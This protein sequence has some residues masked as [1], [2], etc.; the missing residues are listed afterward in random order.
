MSQYK[1][2]TQHSAF[3][4]PGL[5]QPTQNDQQLTEMPTIELAPVEVQQTSDAPLTGVYSSSGFDM[6]GV[7]SR[8]VNRYTT[9][10]QVTIATNITFKKTKPS[11]QL[12][13]N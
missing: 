1:E 2:K 7:L 4:I 6:I 10:N 9:N 5:N 12:G 3:N 13:T 11:N 8:L